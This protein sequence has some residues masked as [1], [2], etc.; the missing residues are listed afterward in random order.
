MGART[1]KTKDMPLQDGHHRAI[2]CVKTS[3]NGQEINKTDIMDEEVELHNGHDMTSTDDNAAVLVD[4]V[5]RPRLQV[6][7]CITADQSYAQPSGDTRSF[8]PDCPKRFSSMHSIVMDFRLEDQA[9]MLKRHPQRYLELFQRAAALEIDSTGLGAFRVMVEQEPN[10]QYK[11]AKTYFPAFPFLLLPPAVRAQVAI[12]LIKSGSWEIVGTCKK[13]LMELGSLVSLHGSC[14]IVIGSPKHIDPRVLRT[15]YLQNIMNLKLF[16]LRTGGSFTST[17]LDTNMN[18]LPLFRGAHV[19]RQR[20]EL[21]LVGVPGVLWAITEEFFRSLPPIH[22]FKE[23]MFNIRV[24]KPVVDGTSKTWD[25]R[26]STYNSSYNDMVIATKPFEKIL[27]PSILDDEGALFRPYL[28]RKQGITKAITATS[29]YSND[30]GIFRFSTRQTDTHRRMI[31]RGK[32]HVK[33]PP[34]ANPVADILKV[35]T[36]SHRCSLSRRRSHFQNLKSLFS[37]NP[38]PG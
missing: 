13:L 26:N 11:M 19:I 4:E 23:F 33:S 37:R 17:I 1:Y 20:L 32:Y 22:L 35:K 3:G 15:D 30:Q 38:D 24:L 7:R 6:I 16:V 21:T 36:A 12:L 10:L 29:S 27:G 25:W 14:K 2:A 5:S 28:H 18:L 9:A 31:Y 8:D 34:W